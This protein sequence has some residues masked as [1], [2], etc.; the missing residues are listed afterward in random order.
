MGFLQR[1]LKKPFG[2]TTV[3]KWNGVPRGTGQGAA[4]RQALETGRSKL[5]QAGGGAQWCHGQDQPQPGLGKW[6]RVCE[7]E[8]KC[9]Y[10]EA[11]GHLW[12]A[13]SLCGPVLA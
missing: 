2:K 7:G 12:E 13:Q 9:L 11:T 10:H 5:S 8:Y 3:E 1:I 6:Y 4:L